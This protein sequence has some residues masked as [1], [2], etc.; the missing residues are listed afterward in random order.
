MLN[1]KTFSATLLVSTCFLSMTSPSFAMEKQEED[2][3]ILSSLSS[4]PPSS[5][6]DSVE[7]LVPTISSLSVRTDETEESWV[8]PMSSPIDGLPSFMEFDQDG[9]FERYSLTL[10]NAIAYE[11]KYTEGAK[12][13]LEGIDEALKALKKTK[14]LDPKGRLWSLYYLDEY[15]KTVN[16]HSEELKSQGINITDVP[17]SLILK[18]I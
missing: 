5:S 16:E 2:S 6:D 11:V 10:E 15:M 14:R 1:F 13:I 18:K 8:F 17:S 7:S 3:K 9:E 12:P 4:V